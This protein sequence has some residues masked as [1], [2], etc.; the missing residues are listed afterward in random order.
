MIIFLWF[1]YLVGLP[2]AL[3]AIGDESMTLARRLVIVALWPIVL[4]GGL[5]IEWPGPGESTWT[6]RPPWYR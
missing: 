4:I 5:I 2:A 6:T 1:V 3:W